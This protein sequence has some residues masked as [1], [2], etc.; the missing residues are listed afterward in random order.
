MINIESFRKWQQDGNRAVRIDMGGFNDTEK[1]D[2]FVYD[3][4]LS[5]GQGVNSVEE[6]DLESRRK[7]QLEQVMKELSELSKNEPIMGEME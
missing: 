6:I 1:F 4:D 3:Y 7:A 2:V 5:I